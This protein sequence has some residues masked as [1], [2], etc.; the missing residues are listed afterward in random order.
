MNYILMWLHIII[1][2]YNNVMSK[3][4]CNLSPNLHKMAT[5][6]DIA[7]CRKTYDW[8]NHGTQLVYT[9][10]L[11]SESCKEGFIANRYQTEFMYTTESKLAYYIYIIY[12][13]HDRQIRWEGIRLQEI[14]VGRTDF[15]IRT[16]LNRAKA[17]T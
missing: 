13:I 14:Q 9:K 8:N 4:V 11:R 6:A 2:D 17:I 16:S 5:T 1:S 7:C 12:Y 10:Y 15:P 3:K